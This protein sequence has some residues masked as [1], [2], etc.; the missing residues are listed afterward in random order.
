LTLAD[1]F[2]DICPGITVTVQRIP[3]AEMEALFQGNGNF[4]DTDMIFY[5][6]VLLRQAVAANA[7]RPLSDLLDSALVQQLRAEALLQQMRPIAVDGMRVDGVLY[8]API[9]VDPQT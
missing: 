9:L 7:L 4:P 1:G 6:H 5:R 3:L 8:G 2:S